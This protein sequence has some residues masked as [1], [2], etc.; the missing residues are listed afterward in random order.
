MAKRGK[1]GGNTEREIEIE[2]ERE[3]EREREPIDC[4]HEF[5]SFYLGRIVDGLMMAIPLD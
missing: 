4:C 1:E 3:R 5:E 2:R